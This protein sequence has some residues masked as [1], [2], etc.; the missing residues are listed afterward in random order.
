MIKKNT[1]FIKLI[2]TIN[3]FVKLEIKKK[4]VLLTAAIFQRDDSKI[5]RRPAPQSPHAPPPLLRS[6]L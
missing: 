3:S 5:H 4:S 2:Y 1:C 6:R